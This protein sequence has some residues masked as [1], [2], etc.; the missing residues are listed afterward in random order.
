MG[1]RWGWASGSFTSSGTAVGD[2]AP[3]AASLTSAAQQVT[4]ASAP[5]THPAPTL[6]HHPSGWGQTATRLPQR[7][8]HLAERGALAGRARP[9][10][11][12]RAWATIQHGRRLAALG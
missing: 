4:L 3:R 6:R 8:P 2:L 11:S 12:S 10:P 1:W 5:T 7:L 9:W